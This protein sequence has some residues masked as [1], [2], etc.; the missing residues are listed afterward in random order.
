MR[1]H[2]I[3]SCMTVGVFSAL[4]FFLRWGQVN[5]SFETDTGLLIPGSFWTTGL[6]IFCVIAAGAFGFLALSLQKRAMPMEYFAAMKVDTVKFPVAALALGLLML[7]GSI[8]IVLNPGDVVLMRWTGVLGILTAAAFPLI[9]SSPRGKG[10]ALACTAS[11]IPVVFYCC[12]IV[13]VYQQNAEN[14]VVWSYSIEI[15]AIAFSA[16]GF[17]YAA[18]YVFNRPQ[19]RR[20]VFFC[21]LGAFFGITAIGDFPGTSKSLI[22][23]A[24]ALMQLLVAALLISNSVGGARQKEHN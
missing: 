2:S 7:V 17:Y 24:S 18:G 22:L 6:V 12:W 1:K 9:A 13:A 14:P 16:L 23:V 19:P 5:N 10:G 21:L 8:G 15:L 20:T 4:A 3:V 11:F